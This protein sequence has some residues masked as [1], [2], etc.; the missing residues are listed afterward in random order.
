METTDGVGGASPVGFGP[1]FDG[2]TVGAG[3]HREAAVC[4][5]F[6]FRA[7]GVRIEEIDPRPGLTGRTLSKNE[8]AEFWRRLSGLLK[9][10]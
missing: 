5:R 10:A 1:V 9:A 4:L 8:A 2:G 3:A 6:T 7:G